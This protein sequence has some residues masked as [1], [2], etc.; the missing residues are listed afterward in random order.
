MIRFRV[1]V[2]ELKNFVSSLIL[3]LEEAAPSNCIT[4]AELRGWEG[5]THAAFH[6]YSQRTFAEE[7]AVRVGHLPYCSRRESRVI[8]M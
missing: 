6:K 4:L 7:S 8:Q 2:P 5:I 3:R 1:L